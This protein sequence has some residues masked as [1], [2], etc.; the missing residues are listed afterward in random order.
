MDDLQ[1][2]SQEEEA[3]RLLKDITPDDEHMKRNRYD[4]G[5][6]RMFRDAEDRTLVIDA[7]QEGDR[8]FYFNAPRLV[9]QL[10]ALL[11][12]V[13]TQQAHAVTALEFAHGAILEAIGLEDGLDGGAGLRVL[14]MI[15]AAL[16]ANGR[17]PPAIPGEDEEVPATPAATASIEPPVARVENVENKAPGLCT[18][19]GAPVEEVRAAQTNETGQ[20]EAYIVL[21][22]D[23]RAKGFIRP[24][25]DTYRHV[26][27]SVCGKP[28]QL[29]GDARPLPVVCTDDVNHEGE[30]TVFAPVDSEAA[31][32]KARD[33]HVLG[34]CGSV[35]TMG[36]ALSETYARNPKFYGATFCVTCNRHLPVAEFVW[37]WDGAVVGS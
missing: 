34:G 33:R 17:Q 2:Q 9:R 3:E 22:A 26:G 13:R 27:R 30:C 23:E 8:E 12:V 28:R 7:Y 5:G 24:Y 32:M 35:T 21:C 25:R 15:R 11:S 14:Q 10:L 31:L 6:G 1:R 18:T 19:S 36:R 29:E 20:H 4:H 16:L 37:V